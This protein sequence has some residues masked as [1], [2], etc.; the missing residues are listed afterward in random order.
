[1]I[2]VFS[3]DTIWVSAYDSIRLWHKIIEISMLV[4]TN[5]PDL[6]PQANKYLTTCTVFVRH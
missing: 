2:I 6:M 3:S 1:M 5:L 4:R